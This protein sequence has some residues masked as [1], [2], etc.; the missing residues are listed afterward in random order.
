[1]WKGVLRIGEQQVPVKLY[2]G[3]QD[4]KVHFRLLSK[5]SLNPV[6]QR[7]VSSRTGREV[8]ADKIQKGYPTE[9]GRFV[10]LTD[11]ELAEL[12]PQPSREI[13]VG[14]FPPQD[15]VD[16][17]WY[18]RPYYLGPD[19][20]PAAYAA[21]VD[22]LTSAERVGIAH[23]VMRKNEYVGALRAEGKTLTLV[24]L[25]R[26]GEVLEAEQVPAPTGREPEP[27]EIRMAEQLVGA[28]AGDF[29]PSEFEDEYRKRVLAAVKARAKG[30]VIEPVPFEREPAR[31]TD[32]AAKLE[33][34]LA[35]AKTK[36]TKTRKKAA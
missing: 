36:K 27:A 20:D 21:L 30:E 19:G 8:P 14:T 3:A 25:R 31:D 7:M 33:Q 26:A 11:E 1:M 6:Q 28:L 2:A 4:R 22:A 18:D 23:W 15:S 29:D 35:A 13:H 9:D 32:L 17:G 5:R 10:I 34:S 16:P 12:E 24:T